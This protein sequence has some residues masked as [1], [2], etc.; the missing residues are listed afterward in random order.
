MKEKHEAH[1]CGYIKS[2]QKFAPV[3]KRKYT[4]GPNITVSIRIP[5]EL[6]TRLHKISK[7]YGRSMQS[8]I[9]EGLDQWAAE[10]NI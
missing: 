7:E 6:S 5:K 9:Q 10:H 8:V 1:E 3:R 4:K 2:P